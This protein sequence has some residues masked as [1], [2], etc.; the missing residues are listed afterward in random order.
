LK[1]EARIRTDRSLSSENKYIHFRCNKP[2]FDDPR[3]RLAAAHA[4]DREQVLALVGVAGEESSCHPSPVKFGFMDVPSYPAYD[5][6]ESQRLLAEAGY[7]NGQGLPE[8]EYITSVGFY[9]KTREYS[10]L[11]TAMLQEQ[12]FPVSLTTLEPA[13]WEQQLYR[14]EDGQ[15]PGHIVDVGWLT[16]SP[17]PD[18]I[19]R[20]NYY[21]EHALVNG[22]NDPEIDAVLDKE[23][24]AKSIEERLKTLQEETLPMIAA[25]VPSVSLFSS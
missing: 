13:S 18:L 15:G 3:V 8:I 2:P 21:S 20:P 7:P 24:N 11:I 19:L 17:E 12:G 25:R 9:P 1:E 16:G 4:I 14:R 5:P 23:R 22:I 10:E 6:A